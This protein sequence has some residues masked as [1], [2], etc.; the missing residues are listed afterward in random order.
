MLVTQAQ[1]WLCPSFH[2]FPRGHCMGLNNSNRVFAPSSSRIRV[3]IADPYPV[4]V[5]GVRKMVEDDPRFQVVADASTMQAFRKKIIAKQPDVALVD[6]SM[7][8]QD[9]AGTTALLQSGPHAPSIIFLSV[10]ENSPHKQEM[11]R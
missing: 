9:L 4:I 3:I 2:L 6:W 11:L 7:A 8:S 5:H 10:S 1:E